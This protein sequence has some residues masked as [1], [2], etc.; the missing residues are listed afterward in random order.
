MIL[1]W[2][3]GTTFENNNT[4]EETNNEIDFYNFNSNGTYNEWLCTTV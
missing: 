4:K 3:N 1:L 2:H